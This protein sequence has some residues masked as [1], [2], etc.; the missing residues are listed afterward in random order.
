MGDLD[1]TQLYYGRLPATKPRQ[2]PAPVRPHELP[3]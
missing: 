3:P 1:R 2:A